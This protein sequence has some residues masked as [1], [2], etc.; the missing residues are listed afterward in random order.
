L[1]A[2]TL[3]QASIHH[4]KLLTQAYN[5]LQARCLG[6]SSIT[7]LNGTALCCPASRRP[8]KLTGWELWLCGETAGP[9]FAPDN[10]G[11]IAAFS[12]AGGA[13]PTVTVVKKAVPSAENVD[14]DVLVR[15][16]YR[17]A[18][19]EQDLISQVSACCML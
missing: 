16:G 10:D 8:L 19:I 12:G 2:V 11:D 17:A 13:D 7:A 3:S 14:V 1:A 4:Q 15:A 9:L 18:Q 5:C 6:L